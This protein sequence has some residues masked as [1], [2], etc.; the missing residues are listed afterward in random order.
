MVKFSTSR[1]QRQCWASTQCVNIALVLYVYRFPAVLSR[2]RS[3]KPMRARAH[4]HA[5]RHAERRLP[6]MFTAD[7]TLIQSQC[8][9][10]AKRLKGHLSI[11][12]HW[13]LSDVS[14]T[15]LP[16]CVSSHANQ[17]NSNRRWTMKLDDRQRLR[18]SVLTVCQSA[19]L[20]Y[21]GSIAITWKEPHI[22]LQRPGVISKRGW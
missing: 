20:I 1:T 19:C 8:G 21:C 11:S 3:T 5:L 9:R 18:C 12:A 15:L 22:G 13:R 7:V 17:S 6:L 10:W 14:I 2:R 16:S 4:V